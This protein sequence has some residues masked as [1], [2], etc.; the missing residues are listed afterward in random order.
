MP[1]AANA[2]SLRTHPNPQKRL[3][4]EEVTQDERLILQRAAGLLLTWF[5]A[6]HRDMPW[7]K[8]RDPYAIWLSEIMLQQTR[9]ETVRAYFARF[10]ARFPTIAALAAAPLD[11]VLTLWSGLGYYA[12]ARNLHAAAQ[13]VVA[14]HGGKFPSD[15]DAVAA[16]PGIG[17]YT[18]G[19]ILSI[20]FGQRAPI[21][22]GNVI[23]VLARLFALDLLPDTASGKRRYWALAAALLPTH[24]DGS[25][26][27]DNDPGD[28]NQAMMEL[29]ATLCVPH[30]PSCLVCPLQALCTASQQGMPESY[31]LAKEKRAVPVV[32]AMTLLC[33]TPDGQVL[34]VKRP[35]V[36][37]WGGLWEPPT[38]WLLP[39]ETPTAGLAR[40]AVERL[41]TKLPLG[42]AVPLPSFV[43][44]LTHREV[45][46]APHLL[47]LPSQPALA[48][49]EYTEARWVPPTAAGTLA[50]S[51]WVSKLLGQALPAQANLS[52]SSQL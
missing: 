42:R 19:A 41:G 23:R 15:P 33:Q 18:M 52:S 31:P 14:Q 10:T 46:V 39:D 38:C 3:G 44:V 13:Q 4:H 51:A 34:L 17:P 11:D 47:T 30:R 28:I 36:G 22:D 9:V 20:A 24:Q 5:R 8:T 32:Q 35:P 48:L 50:L 25:L 16:L 40:L 27:G 2:R 1:P 6:G 21:L 29:G 12:R 43:H 26:D 45:H 49:R 37:L 7:R